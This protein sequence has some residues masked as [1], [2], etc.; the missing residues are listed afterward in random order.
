MLSSCKVSRCRFLTLS[1]MLRLTRPSFL[2]RFVPLTRPSLPDRRP[3]EPDDVL[4][5][6]VHPQWICCRL[7]RNLARLS[8]SPEL[9]CRFWL[10]HL[11]ERR[12]LGHEGP[13]F[14][15]SPCLTFRSSLLIVH[16]LSHHPLSTSSLSILILDRLQLDVLFVLLGK[17]ERFLFSN[18]HS[19]AGIDHQLYLLRL[20]LLL[21]PLQRM[22][23]VHCQDHADLFCVQYQQHSSIRG[24]R[25][26]RG[27]FRS[28]LPVSSNLQSV[29]SLGP[30]CTSTSSVLTPTVS[31]QLSV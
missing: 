24:R 18:H 13:L 30:P 21:Q 11:R 1:A 22:D 29:V 6:M 7:Q 19:L 20:H 28:L 9:A 23:P 26:G 27:R 4:L 16:N 12:L 2:L 31:D 15:L 8:F 25:C 5:W 17:D 3:I 14:I 10:G